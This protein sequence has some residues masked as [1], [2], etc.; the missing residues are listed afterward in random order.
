MENG[1]G[2]FMT[3]LIFIGGDRQAF[4]GNQQFTTRN[5][6]FIDGNT[7][8]Y[9]NF[10]WLWTFHAV[11][12]T[13]CSIGIDMTSGGFD[14]QAVGSIVLLDSSI[15]VSTT[16]IVTPYV[17]DFSS[18]QTAGTLVVE[19]VQFVGPAPAIANSGG[20]VVLA[21]GRTIQSF[22]QGNAW[23]TAGEAITQGQQFNGTTCAYSNT[24]QSSYT[25]Q[26]STI[27]QQ[28]APIPRPSN[29]VTSNGAYFTRA[30]PQYEQYPVSSFLRAKTFAVGNGVT[31]N[32]LSF[33]L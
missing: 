20:R 14:T 30:K 19:N 1:S 23:T 26:E 4:L 13:G 11:T 32:Y 12:I 22:A 5:L 21:G 9:M 3:D 8:I 31:G 6:T 24:T 18:P 15:S 17:P 7:A 29:L 27:Q 25:A 16:G 10:N 28:L 33:F 2:G